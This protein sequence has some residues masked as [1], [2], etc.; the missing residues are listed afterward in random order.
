[1]DE[2]KTIAYL[3]VIEDRLKAILLEVIEL[4]YIISSKVAD[5]EAQ[6]RLDDEG[7]PVT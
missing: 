2:R 3:S 6:D 1:M 4:R 7:G 5:D